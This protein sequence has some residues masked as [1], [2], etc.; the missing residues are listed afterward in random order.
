M[1]QAF[2]VASVRRLFKARGTAPSGTVPLAVL[3]SALQRVHIFALCSLL[4][5]T[6][7]ELLVR[8]GGL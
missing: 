3:S 4:R 2:F 5:G 6:N 1:L 8:R 7:Q